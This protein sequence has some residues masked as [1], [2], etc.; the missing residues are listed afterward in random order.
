MLHMCMPAGRRAISLASLSGSTDRHTRQYCVAFQAP[1][2]M[3]VSLCSHPGH[4]LEGLLHPSISCP[5]MNTL[6]ARQ[7]VLHT[8]VEAHSESDSCNETLPGKTGAPQPFCTPGFSLVAPYLSCLQQ[9]AGLPLTCTLLSKLRS[10]QQLHAG[11]EV[12][13]NG[14]VPF[15]G[16]PAA[17]C[18]AAG[19]Q[20]L[21]VQMPLQPVGEADGT[22]ELAVGADQSLNGLGGRLSQASPVPVLSA[23]KQVLKK[24]ESCIGL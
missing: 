24:Q 17:G 18:T 19:S 2:T 7:P 15:E 11:C 23:A 10:C 1:H 12:L 3:H 20:Q 9:K 5:Q 4:F 13:T 6:K 14:E 16:H 8:H 22:V 21:A